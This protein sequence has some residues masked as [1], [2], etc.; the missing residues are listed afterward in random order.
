M[1][2]RHCDGDGFVLGAVIVRVSD[3]GRLEV[4]MELEGKTVS[5]LGKDSRKV[6]YETVRHSHT[7]AAVC[8]IQQTIVAES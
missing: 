5:W 8:D 2:V 1:V 7:G 3:E 6:T 4:I